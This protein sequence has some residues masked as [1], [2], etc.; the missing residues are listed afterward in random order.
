MP[1]IK[2]EL[3]KGCTHEQKA[4]LAKEITDSVERIAKKR[5]PNITVLFTD[6]ETENWS[7]GGEL[8]SDIDWSKR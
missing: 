1:I 3:W 6:Y 2:V 5:R 7:T 8:A 4:Q